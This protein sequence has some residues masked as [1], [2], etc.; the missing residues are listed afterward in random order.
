[1]RRLPRSEVCSRSTRFL[2]GAW[3]PSFAAALLLAAP[4]AAATTLVYASWRVHSKL[5]P[6]QSP[7]QLV[8]DAAI[9]YSH[10]A[11]PFDLVADFTET[12]LVLRQTETLQLPFPVFGSWSMDFFFNHEEWT[13]GL[14]LASS[15]FG[16]GLAWSMLSPNHLHVSWQGAVPSGRS[17]VAEFRNAAYVP[18][19]ATA[20]SMLLGLAGLGI[21]ARRR[22][23]KPPTLEPRPRRRRARSRGRAQAAAR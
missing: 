6:M 11:V 5:V 13:D 20:L 1:M 17:F 7:Q 4:P 3:L 15:R 18:E 8:S 23:V 22:A 12:Q 9:E 16:S 10:S 14:T 21:Q 19:P 2:R